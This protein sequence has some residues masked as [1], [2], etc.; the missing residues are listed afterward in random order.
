MKSTL[1]FLLCVFAAISIA[2]S[3]TDLMTV[4]PATP[5]AVLVKDFRAMFSLED[6]VRDYVKANVAKGYIVKSIMIWDDE[7]WSKG[8]VVMEKY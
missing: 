6:E 8:V 2:A 1:F 7:N 5:K 4:K 3:T